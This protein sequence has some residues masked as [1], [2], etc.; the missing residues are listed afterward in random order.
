VQWHTSPEIRNAFHLH[1][2]IYCLGQLLS[3]KRSVGRNAG[4][5]LSWRVHCSESPQNKASCFAD[6]AECAIW[7]GNAWHNPECEWRAIATARPA[8]PQ[9]RQCA[10]CSSGNTDLPGVAWCGA[11]RMPC[12]VLTCI[13]E[14]QAWHNSNS[15]KLAV[16]IP[17]PPC[18]ATSQLLLMS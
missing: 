9:S 16:S 18:S 15:C 4:R 17:H 11:N 6:W 7:P 14:L 2:L 10:V 12:V 5:S 1:I 8:G 13:L 3:D